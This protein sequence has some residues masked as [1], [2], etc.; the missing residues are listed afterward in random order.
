M[1]PGIFLINI[2][3]LRSHEEVDPKRI[4]E[5][6]KRITK[7]GCIKNPVVADRKTRVVLDGHHRVA[8]LDKLGL[9]RVPVFLVDYQ[10]D[11]VRVYLRRKE[12]MFSL[13]KEEVINRGLS[14]NRFQNK[15]TR[16]FIKSRPRNINL[17]L[18][19]LI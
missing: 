8:I 15:T 3:Q 6:T 7:D 11:Q 16:H 17:K 14:G 12:M 9:R 5:L 19:R 10:S 4:R 13:I 1:R 18:N 2:D